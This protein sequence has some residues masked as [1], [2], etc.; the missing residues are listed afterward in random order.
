MAWLTEPGIGEILFGQDQRSG[1]FRATHLG[2]LEAWGDPQACAE[3][4]E[5]WAEVLRQSH[6][7]PLI[8]TFPKIARSGEYQAILDQGIRKCLLEKQSAEESLAQIAQQW[9]ALT[10]SI[11]RRKQIDLLKRNE[12]F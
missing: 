7:Q 10:N 1:P 3:M 4:R 8:M 12:S 5:S 11:G 9:E 2:K 6:E